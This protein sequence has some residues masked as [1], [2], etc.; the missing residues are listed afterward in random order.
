LN[1]GLGKLNPQ[2]YVDFQ[3]KF[4][5]T[6]PIEAQIFFFPASSVDLKTRDYFELEEEEK[7]RRK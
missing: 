3:F 5:L 4:S 2:F 1:S 6:K 7:I